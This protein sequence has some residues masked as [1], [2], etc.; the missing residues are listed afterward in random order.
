MKQFNHKVA[1]ITGAGSGIG[2]ATA[3]ELARRGAELWLVDINA[4]GL[5]DTAQQIQAAGGRCHTQVCNVGSSTEMKKLAKRVHEAHPALDILINNA[6]IG[7]AGRFVDTSLKTWNKVL[8]VNVKGVM[9]GCHLF[10]PNMIEQGRGHIVNLASAAAFIAAKDMPVY[11]MSKSAVL[12]FSESL[13]AD[14][15]EYGIGVSAVCPGII[16][17]PIVANAVFEGKLGQNEHVKSKAVDFYKKRNYTADKVALGILDAIEHNLAVRPISPEAWAMYW[18]KRW[19]PGVVD[20][21]GRR[22]IP[23]L[24]D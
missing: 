16:N 2:Q 4:A 11:S 12:G 9:L 18:A 17:T 1:L 8:D 14:L 6:G 5:E 20:W 23:F 7:V 21:L 3:L 19:V 22:D 24:T 15:H 10:A 13:R